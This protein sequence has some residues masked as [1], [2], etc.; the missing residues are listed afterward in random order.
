[1]LHTDRDALVCDMAEVYHV[2]DMR[3]LPGMLVATLACGLRDDSRIKMK[4]AGQQVNMNTALQALILDGLNLLIWSRQKHANRS[5]KPKSV[6]KTLNE[7]GEDREVKVYKGYG[8]DSA[9]ELDAALK[10]IDE[11]G[12]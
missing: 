7:T 9:E 4:M 6:Y 5:N 2:Y 11:K 8:F 3:S 12:Q 1:M 10:R